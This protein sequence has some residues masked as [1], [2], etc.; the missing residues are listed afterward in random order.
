MYVYL[1]NHSY[2]CGA[3]TALKLTVGD[4]KLIIK[5]F[6]NLVILL[7]HSWRLYCHGPVEITELV[8]YR[9]VKCTMSFIWRPVEGPL[10]EV[11]FNPITHHHHVFINIII[12][13]FIV[14]FVNLQN[15]YIL[16]KK[17]P[18]GIHQQQNT[19]YHCDIVFTNRVFFIFWTPCNAGLCI[20]PYIKLDLDSK[21]C[22]YYIT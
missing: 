7:L 16:E 13:L 6:Y 20:I 8:H 2:S 18:Y 11:H 12:I 5:V 15:L 17:S 9:E 22:V 14:N 21:Q 3:W 4:K 10:R 1:C 19:C